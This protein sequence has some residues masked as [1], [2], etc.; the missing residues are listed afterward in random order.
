MKAY[1]FAAN[2]MSEQTGKLIELFEG[3]SCHLAKISALEGQRHRGN[4][5]V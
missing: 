1:E 4:R 2:K 5:L 3:I